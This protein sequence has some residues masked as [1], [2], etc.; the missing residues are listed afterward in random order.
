[1]NAAKRIQKRERNLSASQDHFQ[2]TAAA[3][4]NKAIGSFD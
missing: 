2:Q 1:M 4:K 3:D